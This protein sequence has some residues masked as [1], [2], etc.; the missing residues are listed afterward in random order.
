VA[1]TGVEIG[2]VDDDGDTVIPIDIHGDRR[3]KRARRTAGMVF[4][5]VAA[6]A[7]AIAGYG[8]FL[9]LGS[10]NELAQIE[11]RSADVTVALRNNGQD[12]ST[13]AKLVEANRLY[14]RKLEHPPMVSVI[15]A[16]SQL[17]PDPVW[18]DSVLYTADKITVS[19]QGRNIPPLVEILEKSA[20]FRDVNFASATKRNAELNID[21]FSL[22]AAIEP[23]Q[24][25]Q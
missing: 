20:M 2:Q 12:V 18:L 22:S 6:L 24:V 13:S 10:A 17:L 23:Q 9:A 8:L 7:L 14:A 16:L 15:N 21:E 19:G 1:L 4:A 3:S 11:Q 25:A 5:A